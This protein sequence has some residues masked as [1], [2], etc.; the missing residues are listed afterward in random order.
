MGYKAKFLKNGLVLTAV[1]LIMRSVGMLFGAFISKEVG[2][3]GTGLYTVV[4]TVYS[5]AVTLA[6]SGVSLTVTRHVASLV[7]EKKD[8]DIVGVLRAAIIYSLFFS[9]LATLLLSLG[10]GVIGSYILR[11]GRTVKSLRILSLSLI[12]IALGSV[13]SGYFVG[14]KRVGFNAA[15]QVITQLLR[16][17]VTVVLVLRASGQGIAAAVEAICVGA[18]LTEVIGLL[19]LFIEYIID[20]RIHRAERVAESEAGQLRR[21]AGTALPLAFSAYFRSALLNIEHILIPR[22]LMERGES[23]QESYSHY[24]SLHGMALPMILYPMTVLSSF[25]GL[26]V[27]EFAGDLAAGNKKRMSRIASSALNTALFYAV[28]SAVLL[29]GFSEELGYTVY[30]S[31]DAGRYIALLSP[32]VPIMYLDHVTDQMLKGVGDQVFSMWVN[33]TDSMISVLLVWLLI[34][35]MGIAGY[36]VVI[37][38][39]E[40]YN[41]LL[42]YIRL[43]RRVSFRIDLLSSALAPLA[44]AALSVS[45][46]HLLFPF[47]GSG[48]GGGWLTAKLVFAASLFIALTTIAALLKSSLLKKH[49]NAEKTREQALTGQ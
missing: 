5:F 21:V 12:P 15:V 7:G 28:I 11:D 41:F 45:V 20:R 34:P 24:G 18:T 9:L 26:L 30:G 38:V 6:T 16:V 37:V 39:M 17:A 49:K 25:S 10:A 27:P 14:V 1:A 31:Y 44:L 47:A 19:L 32:I 8:G 2:A 48:V 42:S 29:Y 13:L 23:S 22:K 40:G 46:S 3:E 4:T 43:R 36:A 33:I 35:R